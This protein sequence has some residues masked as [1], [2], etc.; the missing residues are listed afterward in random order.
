MPDDSKPTPV[1]QKLQESQQLQTRSLQSAGAKSLLGD[2]SAENPFPAHI[3]VVADTPQAVVPTA[4]AS[5]VAPATPTPS[6]P[7]PTTP[8]E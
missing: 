8:E 6:A 1:I 7:A 5:D 3:N 2:G 4:S